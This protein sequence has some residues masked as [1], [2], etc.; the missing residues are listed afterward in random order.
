MNGKK[1]AIVALIVALIFFFGAPRLTRAQES[2]TQYPSMAPLEQYLMDRN[3]EIALARSA[4]PDSISRDAKVLVLTR[5]GYE[6]AVEGKNG[7]VCIVE[8]SWVVLFDDPEFWNPKIRG[9]ICYNPPAARSVLAITL[10]RTEMVFAGL[11]PAEM[12]QG[13]RAA[14]DKKELQAP[15]PGA[16][17][18]M[19]SKDQYLGDP[20]GHWHPHLM[21]VVPHTDDIVWGAGL[22]NSP[23]I[24]GA[25]R[26]PE[27][28]TIFVVPVGK[29][30]DGTA[31]PA[32]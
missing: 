26:T 22:P 18:Y 21:F 17:G 11:S 27:P 13:L 8:R 7:F 2:K 10:K 29:W 32:M 3:A 1:I 4:A 31:G 23:I 16:L 15:E 5:Y 20:W 28:V 30:S 24:V 25:Q 12:N 9:P 6:T 14:V 19:M